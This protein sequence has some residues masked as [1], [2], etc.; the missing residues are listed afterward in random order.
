MCNI[1]TYVYMYDFTL[2]TCV[3]LSRVGLVINAHDHCQRVVLWEWCVCVCVVC[4]CVCVWPLSASRPVR[5][6]YEIWNVYGIWNMECKW[7]IHISYAMYMEYGIWNVHM[8]WNMKFYD[9]KYEI[10]KKVSALHH[11]CIKSLQNWLVRISTLAGA[12][13]ITFLMPASAHRVFR[14]LIKFE[15]H[16]IWV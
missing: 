8:T 14:I 13:K 3:Y 1:Y 16:Y 5:M 11:S 9:M 7:S 12:E 4:V 2:P 6:Q 10:F 15:F